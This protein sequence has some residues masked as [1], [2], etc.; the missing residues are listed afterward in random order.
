MVKPTDAELDK[1]TPHLFLF[2]D[3]VSTLLPHAA[4]DPSLDSLFDPIAALPQ[5]KD[6]SFGVVLYKGATE[7]RAYLHRPDENWD[8]G[9]GGKTSILTAAVVLRND[10]RVLMANGLITAANA[11]VLLRYVWTR[12]NL[13]DIKKLSIGSNYPQP[14]QMFDFSQSPIDFEGGPSDFDFL[15]TL[16]P[17]TIKPNDLRAITFR[18]RLHLTIGHS[19]NRAARASQG[20]LGIAYINAVLQHLGLYSPMPDNGLRVAGPYSVRDTDLPTGWR[21][22]VAIKRALGQG[23]GGRV[24][25]I[26]YCA[27]ARTLAMLMTSMVR[28]TFPG[29]EGPKGLR[30]FLLKRSDFSYRSFALEGVQL[31]RQQM[32]LSDVPTIAY[33]KLGI[34]W[35]NE[36]FLYVE[37]GPIRFGLVM[38]GLLPKRINNE[39]WHGGARGWDLAKNLYPVIHGLPW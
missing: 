26:P 27:T 18:D 12:H 1:L 32:G 23:A 33:S 21:Q 3:P 11:D 28:N 15:K 5:F 17:H 25:D 29:A 31:A 13:R 35:A 10:L 30:E 8:I 34:L 14:S 4:H 36:E 39:P 37:F 2:Q 24:T 22:P 7:V 16:A 6:I 9:S 38:L 20:Q 19:D